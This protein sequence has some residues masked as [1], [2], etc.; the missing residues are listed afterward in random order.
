MMRAFMSIFKLR[1]IAGLQYRTAAIAGLITQ[2]FWGFVLIMVYREFYAAADGTVPMSLEQVVTYVWLQQS[3]LFFIMLWHRDQELFNLITTGNIAYELCRPSNLYSFW[4]A[5][6]LAQR[7]SGAML[8]CFPILIVALI[9]PAPY[10]LMPSSGAASLVLFVICLLLGLL[11]LVAVSMFIYISVFYTMSPTGSVLMFSVVGEFMAGMIIPVP[12][13]P[14]W[15]QG[16]VRL[17]P[18]CWSADFPFRVF[19][20]HIGVQEALQGIAVQCVWLVC[21]V[22]LGKL[23]MRKALRKVVVQ[24]G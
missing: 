24:G 18:F 9:L 1:M 14:E 11:V 4:Y 2:L 17:F 8:R 16:I 5:K 12:L 21:L 23:A 13:M 10:R 6:L 19:S 15:L 3:F 7:F 22:A 20:G